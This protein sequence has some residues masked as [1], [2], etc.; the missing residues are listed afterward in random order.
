MQ[1][2]QICCS[3]AQGSEHMGMKD[4]EEE[5]RKEQHGNETRTTGEP[6][7]VFLD[8][9]AATDTNAEAS[10]NTSQPYLEVGGV[11]DITTVLSVQPNL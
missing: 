4:D 6:R 1:A 3:S 9:F 8:I 11:G 7:D 2:G 10:N 5:D